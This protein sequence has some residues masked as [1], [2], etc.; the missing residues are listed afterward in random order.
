MTSES[1]RFL[2][3]PSETKPT[4][5]R[6]LAATGTGS[7]GALSDV[8]EGSRTE[9][10][11]PSI[12]REICRFRCF[13]EAD[14]GQQRRIRGLWA[15]RRS[16]SYW[17]RSNLQSWRRSRDRKSRSLQVRSQCTYRAAM[18]ASGRRT[19]LYPTYP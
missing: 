7:E 9:D 10:G 12:L 17:T 1:T 3:Q 8:L 16:R 19:A 14:R 6:T 2:G 5:G 4:V 13:G 11:T 15:Q 18:D